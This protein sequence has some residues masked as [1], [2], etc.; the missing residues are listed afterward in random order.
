MKGSSLHRWRGPLQIHMSFEAVNVLSWVPTPI[1]LGD[2]G[3]IEEVQHGGITYGFWE[4]WMIIIIVKVAGSLRLVW[5]LFFPLVGLREWLRGSCFVPSLVPPLMLFL[6]VDLRFFLMSRLLSF[7]LARLLLPIPM[8]WMRMIGLLVSRHLGRVIL[9][10]SRQPSAYP[11]ED[12]GL[13]LRPVFWLV[14]RR[15]IEW[16]FVWPF[17][18]IVGRCIHL[19]LSLLWS[20]HPSMIVSS[21][22]AWLWTSSSLWLYPWESEGMSSGAACGGT[23]YP[24]RPSMLIRISCMAKFCWVIFLIL[25]AIVAISLVNLVAALPPP[26]NHPRFRTRGRGRAIGAPCEGSPSSGYS[27]VL[28]GALS[29]FELILYKVLSMGFSLSSRVF[30]F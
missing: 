21:R 6:G 9:P 20:V 19:D 22:F 23:W 16:C 14:V 24:P 27:F 18:G 28:L 7:I 25:A 1:I 11:I 2:F 3:E 10:I 15:K 4:R 29:S 8:L 12:T 17:R 30:D 5:V 26:L 13:P